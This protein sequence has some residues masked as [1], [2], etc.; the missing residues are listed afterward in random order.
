LNRR[1]K[2][3]AFQNQKRPAERPAS[4][5]PR[6]ACSAAVLG[7]T[8]QAPTTG[9]G[10]AV[11]PAGD[12]PGKADRVFF[13]QDRQPGPPV[14]SPGHGWCA[15]ACTGPQAGGP[16]PSRKK[17]GGDR[18]GGDLR[19]AGRSAGSEDSASFFPAVPCRGRPGSMGLTGWGRR[20][21]ALGITPPPRVPSG[22]PARAS[23][24]PPWAWARPPRNEL[25]PAGSRFSYPAVEDYQDSSRI[26]L[27]PVP[28]S[29][30]IRVDHGHGTC[31]SR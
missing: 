25:G 19:G 9:F 17:A 4:T 29:E 5:G 1:R 12:R 18:G 26:T 15:R 31:R 7:T 28:G 3:G 6:S 21:P 13:P 11:P 16:R 23:P 8:P 24:R 22:Q 14:V 27:A 10:I 20:G 2:G 30:S